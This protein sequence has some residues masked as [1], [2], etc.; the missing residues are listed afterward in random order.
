LTVSMNCSVSS[1]QNRMPS[2]API[3]PKAV[4]VILTTPGAVDFLVSDDP[5]GV[6]VGLHGNAGCM[7]APYSCETANIACISIA[8]TH[9]RPELGTGDGRGVPCRTM[10][11]RPRQPSGPTRLLFRVIAA[12]IRLFAMPPADKETTGNL[13]PAQNLSFGVIIRY[14]NVCYT[15]RRTY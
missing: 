11:A 15:R 3:H 1:R 4:P 8:A 6:D 12:D 5:S 14:L 9:Q 10:R 2:P 13:S 7:L